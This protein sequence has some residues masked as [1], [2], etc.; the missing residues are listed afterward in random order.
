MGQVSNGFSGGYD[1]RSAIKFSNRTNKILEINFIFF[2]KVAHT[3]S[4]GG[5]EFDTGLEKTRSIN[6]LSGLPLAAQ[7]NREL[8][9]TFDYLMRQTIKYIIIYRY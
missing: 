6:S 3:I 9:G 7:R 2:S 8:Y 4:S 1:I 5:N